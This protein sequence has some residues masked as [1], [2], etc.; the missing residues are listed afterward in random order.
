MLLTE[1]CR[2][3]NNAHV[4]QRMAVLYFCDLKDDNARVR[5]TGSINAVPSLKSS[6]VPGLKFH[7]QQHVVKLN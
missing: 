3:S 7:F 2:R 5:Q 4:N 1:T 6:T